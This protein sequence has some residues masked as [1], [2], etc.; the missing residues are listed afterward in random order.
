MMAGAVRRTGP[1]IMSAS[2]RSSEALF[3][4][5]VGGMNG[6]FGVPQ[7]IHL[8]LPVVANPC[9]LGET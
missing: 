8:T 4:A 9:A 2:L 6:A 7:P 1:M 5:F 3:P